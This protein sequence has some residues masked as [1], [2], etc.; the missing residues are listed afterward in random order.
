[1]F[2][3][4]VRILGVF[5]AAVQL[6]LLS[7]NALGFEYSVPF[8]DFMTW[9]GDRIASALQLDAI[10]AMIRD[11]LARFAIALPELGKHWHHVFVLL[12]LLL[13]SASRFRANNDAEPAP[14]LSLAWFR[15]AGFA[16]VLLAWAAICALLIA[17]AT[18]TVPLSSIAVLLWPLAGLGVFLA[19]LSLLGALTLTKAPWLLPL[20]LG[21]TAVIIALT[22]LF[23]KPMMGPQPP[24]LV[25]AIVSNGP[26][27]LSLVI[28]VGLWGLMFVGFGLLERKTWR[29]RLINPTT[30]IGLDIISA[31]AIAFALAA[32]FGKYTLG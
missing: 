1:M 6:V 11:W 3:W 15:N 14:L 7:M 4:L 17:V 16:F 21:N 9:L 32:V 12:W 19:G 20:A 28:I 18:G 24:Q 27:L 13:G 23:P 31:Y 29:E 30:A 25:F 5:L 26:G 22:Y 10:E 8:E 2:P